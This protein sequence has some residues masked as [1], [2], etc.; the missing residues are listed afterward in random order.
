MLYRCVR[1]LITSGL[2]VIGT[3]TDI[4]IDGIPAIGHCRPTLARAGLALAMRVAIITAATGTATAA[5]SNTTIVGITTMIVT[6]TAGATTTK[7]T[8]RHSS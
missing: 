2:M 6:T 8:A 5:A 1:G 7:Q 4:T 3:R